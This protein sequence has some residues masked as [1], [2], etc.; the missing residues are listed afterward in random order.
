MACARAARAL[1][2]NTLDQRGWP[3]LRCIQGMQRW[4]ICVG[5]AAFEPWALDANTLD[6]SRAAHTR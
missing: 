6:P 2:S 1:R 3:E 5:R 4:L